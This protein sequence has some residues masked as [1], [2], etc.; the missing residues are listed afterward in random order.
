MDNRRWRCG[1][2]RVAMLAAAV[3]LSGVGIVATATS[4]SAVELT[5]GDLSSTIVGTDGDDFIIGEDYGD[6]VSAGMGQ[7]FI[8][9]RG[10]DDWIC[11]GQGDDQ[12][13]VGG[14]ADFIN[15]GG[16]YDI[17]VDAEVTRNC[18]RV[19][20]PSGATNPDQGDVR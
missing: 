16:G 20:P 4:A 14:G 12:I 3:L 13:Y 15:G 19:I 2:K 17:C 8:Y 11:G 10:G 9:T 1:R 5:C 6:V 18:E 7:D